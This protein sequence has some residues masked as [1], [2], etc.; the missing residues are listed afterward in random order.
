MLLYRRLTCDG[1]YQEMELFVKFFGWFETDHTVF[2][3]ME[4]FKFGD[5]G[6]YLNHKYTEIEVK[7]I[8]TDLLEGLEIMHTEGFAHRDL[9]PQVS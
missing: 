2:L 5:L 7:Q 1:Q 9:K 6:N 4:Y 8:T 3:A